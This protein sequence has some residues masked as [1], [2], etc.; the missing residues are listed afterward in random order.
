MIELKFQDVDLVVLE[1]QNYIKV[2]DGPGEGYP[3][4][5]TLVGDKTPNETYRSTY[6]HMFVVMETSSQI[7][8]AK[9][10]KATYDVVSFVIFN[11]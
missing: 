6:N 7:T 1:K 10:F 11:Y 8:T 5:V 3:L 9:G 4:L 2:F